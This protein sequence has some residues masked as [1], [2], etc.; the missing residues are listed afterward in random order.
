MPLPPTGPTDFDP[1][2]DC[3]APC[4]KACP[5]Q[6]FDKQ[7]LTQVATGEQHLPARVGDYSRDKCAEMMLENEAQAEKKMVPEI[8]GE[9]VEIIKYCR[10]CEFSCP[11]GGQ[12]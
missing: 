2:R 9:P 8:S 10:N 7:V 11:L 12:A 5:N 3:E 4:L 6:A 1:C